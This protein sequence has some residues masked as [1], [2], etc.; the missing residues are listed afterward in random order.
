[1]THLDASPPR[2]Y[3]Y[4]EWSWFL[5][6][7]GEDENNPKNHRQLHAIKHEQERHGPGAEIGQGGFH[8]GRDGEN[9]IVPW[10]WLGPRSPLISSTSEPHWLLERLMSAFETEPYE[11]T[12]DLERRELEDEGGGEKEEGGTRVFSSITTSP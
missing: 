10:S 6:I 11:K 5:K 4:D 2:R 8:G 9:E 3:K 12:V 7:L 1:M